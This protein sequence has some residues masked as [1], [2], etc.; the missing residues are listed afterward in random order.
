MLKVIS[1][2]CTLALAGASIV[3]GGVSVMATMQREAPDLYTE[4]MRRRHE[5]RAGE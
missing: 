2:L 5:R 1:A 4:W 3:F